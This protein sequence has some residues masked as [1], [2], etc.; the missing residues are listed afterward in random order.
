MN[1]FKTTSPAS[2]NLIL[3]IDYLN[4]SSSRIFVELLVLIKSFSSDT[5]TVSYTWTYEEEDEDMLELG[6]DLAKSAKIEFKFIEVKT[7]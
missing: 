4:T 1:N 6:E 7:E 5:T 2:I 3:E